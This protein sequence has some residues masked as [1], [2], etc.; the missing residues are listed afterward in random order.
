MKAVLLEES[1]ICLMGTDFGAGSFDPAFL[2]EP[3][4]TEQLPGFSD[5][6][7]NLRYFLTKTKCLLLLNKLKLIRGISD[8]FRIYCFLLPLNCLYTI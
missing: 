1:L 7:I 3:T 8:H 5:K 2:F 4:K 6:P